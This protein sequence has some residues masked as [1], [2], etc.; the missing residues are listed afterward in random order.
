MHTFLSKTPPLR[1]YISKKKSLLNI[2]EIAN[3]LPKLLLTNNVQNKINKLKVNELSVDILLKNKSEKEINLAMSHLSF[4]AH[5]FMWGG[6]KPEK[7]LPEVIS[8]PWVK[9]SKYLKRPP[10]LS[11]ASYCSNPLLG[12]NLPW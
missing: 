10:I 6:N 4:I 9:L 12:P 8:K 3:E 5:A 11:Y 2:T 7:I 1:D